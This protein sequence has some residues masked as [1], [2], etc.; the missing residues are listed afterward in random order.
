LSRPPALVNGSPAEL[1]SVRDRG[2][3]YGDG[4]FETMRA[5]HG[6]LRWFERHL[7]RLAL[8]CE[9]LG[10][11]PPDGALLRGEAESLAGSAPRALV[12]VILTRGAATARGYRPA[13]DERPTRIVS[14]HEWPPPAPA[15][16]RAGLSSVRLGVNPLLAG[17]KHLNRLEQVLAQ[18][19]AGAIGLDEVLMASSA[20]ELVGGSMSNVFLW[21]DDLLLTPPVADCGVA[22]VMRSLVLEAAAGLGIGLRIVPVPLAELTR[23]GAMFVS[24]VR[25]GVQPVHWFEGRR[26][27]VDPRTAQLQEAI[28]GAPG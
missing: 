7:A 12:K 14:M 28:D 21:F 17:I 2:L 15:E 25:L 3:Q 18:R 24:N 10:L 9:R 20:G 26:L 27:G 5:E 19:A 23:A 1:V 22:G 13:G 8:G 6:R 16:W 11:P 4:L